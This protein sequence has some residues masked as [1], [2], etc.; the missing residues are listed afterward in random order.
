L[1][2]LHPNGDHHA[3]REKLKLSSTVPIKHGS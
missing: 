3:I 2:Q 1:P